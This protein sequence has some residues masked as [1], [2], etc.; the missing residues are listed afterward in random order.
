MHIRENTTVAEIMTHM[1]ESANLSLVREGG[2]QWIAEVGSIRGVGESAI[3]AL[4]EVFIWIAPP[5]QRC[6]NCGNFNLN[7]LWRVNAEGLS[8]K[9]KCTAC[10]TDFEVPVRP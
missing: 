1:P 6:P 2:G 9:W 8:H 4:Y 7:S 5:E 3:Q 10:Y